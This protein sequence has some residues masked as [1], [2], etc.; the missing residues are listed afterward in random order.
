MQEKSLYIKKKKHSY[1]DHFKKVGLSFKR[2]RQEDFKFKVSLDYIAR[3]CLKKKKKHHLN[4]HSGSQPQ[5]WPNAVR[6]FSHVTAAIWSRCLA[7]QPHSTT[8]QLSKAI[9]M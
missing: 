7:Q 8:G 5:V 4:S 6:P 1:T 2:Q 9:Q 3:S